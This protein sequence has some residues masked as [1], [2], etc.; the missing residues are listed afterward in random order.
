MTSLKIVND[1]HAC[2]KLSSP[3][4]LFSFKPGVIL[5]SNPVFPANSLRSS[6]ITGMR[7]LI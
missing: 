5:L 4:P 1:L 6:S 2:G 7:K 3:H